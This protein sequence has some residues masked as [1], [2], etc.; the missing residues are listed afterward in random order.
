MIKLQRLGHVLMAV[1]DLDASKKFYIDLLGFKLLEQDPE[2]GGVFLSIGDYGNTLDLFPSTD[3]AA[4]PPSANVIG[5]M[6]GLGVK[7]V[8][9][10]VATEEELKESYFA[11][12]EAGVKIQRALNHESQKSIYFHDPDGNLL[13]IVWEQPNALKIFADGRADNDEELSFTR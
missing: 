11:L 7:H 5:S 1:R 10:A 2:H 8:A 12:C 13:E 6:L 9:F 3:P 4:T